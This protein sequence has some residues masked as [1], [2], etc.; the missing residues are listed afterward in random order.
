MDRKRLL[1]LLYL[2]DREC[3][4]SSGRPI[5]GGKLVAL[6]HGPIHSEVYDLIKGSGRDQAEWSHH[7]INEDYR[8][9]L[10]DEEL[11][12][13]SLSRY[14]IDLLN[15]ISAKYA[16]FGTWDVAD[17]THLEEYTKNYQ[18]GNAMP[19]SLEDLVDAVGPKAGKT[20]II[21]DAKEKAVM[22][23]LFAGKK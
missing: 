13:A 18:A 17:A 12:I 10:N 11:R 7:F 23:A 15:E 3:L 16:G 1:A 5:I 14:E 8:V 2:S 9:K 20:A 19:I 6:K 4:K 22:D 21:T